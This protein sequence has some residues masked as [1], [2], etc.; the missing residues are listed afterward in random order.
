MENIDSR[1]V[2]LIVKYLRTGDKYSNLGFT[3]KP[4]GLIKATIWYGCPNSHTNA[5]VLQQDNTPIPVLFYATTGKS[6]NNAKAKTLSPE[7]DKTFKVDTYNMGNF[8][9][10]LKC[11]IRSDIIHSDS[12]FCNRPNT[13][14]CRCY[15][16][17]PRIYVTTALWMVIITPSQLSSQ[18]P[19]LFHN[20]LRYC[21]S[22]LSLINISL[23]IQYIWPPTSF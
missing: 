13:Y 16:L 6:L 1:Q 3:Q 9:M 5:Q 7:S 2:L 19:R 22:A 15:N 8:I 11:Y 23:V 21:S 18:L 4:G 20:Y 12:H 14:F 10:S 17:L